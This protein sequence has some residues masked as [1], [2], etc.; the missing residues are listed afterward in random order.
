MTPASV[1]L[2]QWQILEK[3]SFTSS[4][5]K[6]T[7]TNAPP[8]SIQKTT[9]EV[10]IDVDADD[11]EDEDIRRQLDH[12]EAGS[13]RPIARAVTPPP[14]YK[15]VGAPSNSTNILYAQVSRGGGGG[16][17]QPPPVSRSPSV[18]RM[19]YGSRG[20]GIE[21]SL[22]SPPTPSGSRRHSFSGGPHSRPPSPGPGSR[23]ATL[24]GH[25][26]QAPSPMPYVEETNSPYCFKGGRGLQVVINMVS[27]T[28]QYLP[29]K[30]LEIQST[31]LHP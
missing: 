23:R 12:Q 15:G 21:Q 27:S 1:T 16:F 2:A 10:E 19:N 7:T 14:S 18:H 29:Y 8:P 3:R 31:C 9:T 24:E 11:F 25:Y 13:R 22:K 26:S 28:T 20:G 30:T 4:T 6:R 17:D 5:T